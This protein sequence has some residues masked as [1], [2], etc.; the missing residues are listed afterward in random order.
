MVSTCFYFQVHQPYRLRKY[1]IFEIGK[2]RDYFSDRSNTDLNNGKVLRKVAGK[3]YLPT[4]KAMLNLIKRH[5]EFKISYSISG[6]A[7]DQFSEYYPDVLLSF[8]E[9]VD[10]GNVEM[11]NETYYHSL[12]YL[13]SKEEFMRQVN[14]HRNKIKKLF[15][16]T[17]K[18]F[19]NTEL[20]YNNHLAKTM[21]DEGYKGILAEGVDRILEWRSPNFL[22]QP[23]TTRNI[24]LL[25]KNYKLSDDIAFRFSNRGWNDWPLTVSKFTQ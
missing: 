19:R 24:K 5:P 23:T 6:I 21:E 16:Q 20:I 4:N 22:Y 25:L 8:Q 2:N 3:C 12:S 11:L 13:Y 18:V 14:L 17:P 9:L 7:L 15:G 10:T 1:S